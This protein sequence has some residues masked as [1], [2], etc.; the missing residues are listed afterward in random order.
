MPSARSKSRSRWRCVLAS[1]QK[2]RLVR[3]IPADQ[4]EQER[5][6]MKSLTK[7][8]LLR[9]Y[10]AGWI[11]RERLDDLFERHAWLRSA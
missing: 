2:R 9:L 8:L 10:C 7:R 11:S 3:R 1:D 4:Q 6:K 5:L